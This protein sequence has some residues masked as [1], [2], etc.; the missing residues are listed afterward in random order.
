MWNNNNSYEILIGGGG[1]SAMNLMLAAIRQSK[2]YE[3]LT[4]KGLAIL[5]KEEGFGTSK[6]ESQIVESI[7]NSYSF[8]KII[9]RE[10]E[11]LLDNQQFSEII[12]N[13]IKTNKINN[14]NL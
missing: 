6:I 9:M 11:S 14:N 10:P 4:D 1:F 2:I 8:L 3:L 5:D 13:K 7:E 12:K